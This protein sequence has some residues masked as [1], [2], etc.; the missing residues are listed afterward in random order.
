MSVG[1]EHM[2]QELLVAFQHPFSSP[3]L[4]PIQAELTHYKKQDM[5]DTHIPNPFLL[6][7][8]KHVTIA[9]W[10]VNPREVSYRRFSFIIKKKK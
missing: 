1:K 6:L 8:S 9:I 10:P 5:L 2:W 4:S 3:P 7:R